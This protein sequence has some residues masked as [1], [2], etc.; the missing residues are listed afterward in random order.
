MNDDARD[1]AQW[2][3]EFIEYYKK[4]IANIKGSCGRFEKSKLTNRIKYH[5]ILRDYHAQSLRHINHLIQMDENPNL[6]LKEPCWEIYKISFSFWP[7]CK[8]Y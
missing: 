8:P 7:Q 5:D 6:Q 4:A 2:D 1:P 3:Y